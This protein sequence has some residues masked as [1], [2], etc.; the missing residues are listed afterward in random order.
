MQE[1]KQFILNEAQPH[2]EMIQFVKSIKAEYGLKVGVVSNEGGELAVDRIRRFD[3][4]NFVD[5]FIIS[6][7]VH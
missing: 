2:T 3:L 6:S 7:F 5:F 1:V 4:G